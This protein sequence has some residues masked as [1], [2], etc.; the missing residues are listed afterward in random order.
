VNGALQVTDRPTIFALGDCAAVPTPDGQGCY[1]PTAQNAIRQGPVAAANIVS[2]I[3]G[4]TPAKTFHYRPMGSLASLGQ[5]QAVAQ[6]GKMHF[7]G[8][9][10]WFAWRGVYLTKLPHFGEKLRVSVDWLTDLFAPVDTTQVPIIKENLPAVLASLT[11]NAVPTF[12]PPSG[13]PPPATPPTSEPSA[14]DS[15]SPPQPVTR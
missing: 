4:E 12:A 9:L 1:A 10:A 6:M 15:T 8:L 11:G 3:H 14:T 13:S 7:S 2:L 5:R